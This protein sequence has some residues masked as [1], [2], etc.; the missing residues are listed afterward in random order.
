MRGLVLKNHFTMTAD[1]AALV[2]GGRRRRSVGGI[3][4]NRPVGGL[5]AEAVRTVVDMEGKR[6]RSCGC[7]PRTPSTIAC[8]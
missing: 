1:R 7:P 8:G 3:V 2:M 6:E 5:N 4:L